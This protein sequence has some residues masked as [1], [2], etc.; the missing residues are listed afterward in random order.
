MFG[1]SLVWEAITSK[2]T[3]YEDFPVLFTYIFNKKKIIVILFLS[4]H[5]ANTTS[6]VQKCFFELDV[7]T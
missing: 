7:R 1:L 6:T 5:G 2:L 4:L 3:I